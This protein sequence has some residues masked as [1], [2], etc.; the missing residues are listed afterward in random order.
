ME[1]VVGFAFSKNRK[2]VLLICKNRPEWQKGCLNGIGGKVEDDPTFLAAMNRECLEETGLI[3]NW[4]QKGIMKG[5]NDDGKHFVCHIFYAY[6]DDIYKYQQKEDEELEIW[7]VH[8][9]LE[10]VAQR[11]TNLN[12]LIPFGIH[13]ENRVFMELDYGLSN[14]Y[15]E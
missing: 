14:R 2:N 5:R 8:D 10:S 1:Y 4:Q 3:L 11:V 7:S 15:Y 13:E 12:W 9:F 6:S